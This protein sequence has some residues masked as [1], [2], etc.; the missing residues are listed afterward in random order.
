M[1]LRLKPDARILITRTDR[2]GDVVLSTPVIAAIKKKYPRAFLGALCLPATAPILEG[3]PALDVILLYDKKGKQKRWW[4]S[5]AYGFSLRKHRFD[6]AIHLHPN[7]RVHWLSFL[8][9][10]PVRIGYQKKSGFLL[11][12]SIT[13][14]KYK[15]EK[16]EAE[17]N[18]DLLGFLDVPTPDKPELFFPLDPKDKTVVEQ[19]VLAA[20]LDFSRPSFALHVG[21]SGP[22]KRWP[23]ERF[24]A[25]A[26]ELKKEYGW[27]VVLVGGP[28]TAMLSGQLMQLL[29]N[30]AIDL[31]GKLTLKQLG[32]LFKMVRFFL[33]SDSG[34]VHVAAAVKTPVLSLFGRTDP[35]LSPKR[36][37]PLGENSFYLHK[38]PAELHAEMPKYHHDH[39]CFNQIEVDDVIRFI[40][41]RWRDTF[42]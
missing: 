17:Y 5:F 20:G 27:Q 38:P 24:A 29:G 8:A 16:H 18:F 19:L 41:H 1:S 42:C 28:E 31:T 40:T 34:P 15:G 12:H 26:L 35:G 30:Q 6:V 37:H 4:Q 13:D 11:T 3:N 36:W 9:G 14:E 10:I 22:E 23:I 39:L 2:I 21:A 25:V 32:W 33:S 7:H